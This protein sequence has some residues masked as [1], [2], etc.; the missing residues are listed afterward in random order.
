MPKLHDLHVLSSSLF[1]LQLHPAGHCRTAKESSCVLGRH[2]CQTHMAQAS[3]TRPD[4]SSKLC[5][6]LHTS[7]YNTCRNNPTMHLD[8][9]HNPMGRERCRIPSWVRIT[10]PLPWVNACKMPQ[11]RLLYSRKDV[12][13][14]AQKEYS[15][16]SDVKVSVYK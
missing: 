11:N 1:Q 7:I 10:L 3:C 6:S 16:S 14:S 5:A 2:C 13:Y 12:R 8:F 4:L 9:W 15:F